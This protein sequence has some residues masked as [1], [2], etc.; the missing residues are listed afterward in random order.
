MTPHGSETVSSFILAGG[1]SSRM[2]SN[3][4]FLSC[5][6]KTFLETIAEALELAFTVRPAV[7]VSER[8]KNEFADWEIYFE[9]ITD[10]IPDLGPISG[11]HTALR[12]CEKEFS[13]IVA[14]DMPMIDPSVM[15]ELMKRLVDSEKDAICIRIGEAIQPMPSIFRTKRCL[16]ELENG[17]LTEEIFS[18]LFL[19][20]RLDTI[21]VDSTE[22]PFEHRIY[23]NVNL[24]EDLARVRGTS[25]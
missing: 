15:G 3:K 9:I 12:N 25:D 13:A 18:P 8:N 5:G 19:I 20:R 23:E 16:E 2:G 1:A 22:L 4:A 24:P 6:G 21:V 10:V 7:I 14:V 11:I 17:L